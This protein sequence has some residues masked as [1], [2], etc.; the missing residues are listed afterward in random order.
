[1]TN[2]NANPAFHMGSAPDVLMDPRAAAS[3]LGVSVATLADWRCRGVGPKW[4]KVGRL[5]RYRMS[6]LQLWLE[7]R[8]YSNTSE[9]KGA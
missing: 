3:Y 2:C 5:A 4:L 9:A 1:M 6:D 7:R 8:T